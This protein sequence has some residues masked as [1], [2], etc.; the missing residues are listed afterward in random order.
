MAI[1]QKQCTSSFVRLQ[2]FGDMNFLRANGSGSSDA[3]VG[4]GCA[5]GCSF[6]RCGRRRR[7]KQILCLKFT[8]QKQL[9]CFIEIRQVYHLLKTDV[10]MRFSHKNYQANQNTKVMESMMPHLK[11]THQ[12][13]RSF[14]AE[15]CC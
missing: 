6:S 5:H 9:H 1:R 11:P 4:R 2:P 10:E 12:Q 15:G 13:G 3:D 14:W 8:R 7:L